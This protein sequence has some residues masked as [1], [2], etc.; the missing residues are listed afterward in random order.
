MKKASSGQLRRVE[1]TMGE[2]AYWLV[3]KR[4][5]NLNL[6]VKPGG[7]IVL[8]VPLHCSE[9]RADQMIRE[10][11]GWIALVLS[12]MEREDVPLLP[13]CSREETLAC[14]TEAVNRVYPL[15]QTFGVEY[16]QIK[17]RQMRS[18]WGNCLWMQGYITLNIA[19]ARCPECLQDYVALH[20]LIHFLHHDHGFEFR[21]KMDLL[22][23]EWKNLRKELKKYAAALEM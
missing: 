11:S 18:Q 9:Q 12:R 8:S 2:I 17:I 1:T 21:S 5:K 19:L 23:P 4:V 22:M 10:R 14:L 7:E 16:P 3:R 13:V 15:V 20:E 6:R